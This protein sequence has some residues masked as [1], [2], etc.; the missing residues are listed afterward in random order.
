VATIR[1]WDSVTFLAYLGEETQDNRLER[2]E[3]VIDLA[4]GGQVA[5]LTS[6]LTLVE[7]LH[8]KGLRR[9]SQ[10]SEQKIHDFFL[11][12][13]IVVRNV[14]RKIAEDARQLV[15]KQRIEPKD[16]IHV[17]TALA[18][19]ADRLDTFDNALCNLTNKLGSPPLPIDW[20]ELPTDPMATGLYAPPDDPDPV[21]S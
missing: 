1:Y 14:D 20:P 11:H 2:C 3:H 4:K 10:D 15:W 5:I 19:N 21:S 12:E 7:V 6:A 13:W 8:I 16:A 18:N 17:A 9:L